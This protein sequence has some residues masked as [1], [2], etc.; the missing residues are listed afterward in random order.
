MQ[1]DL[2]GGPFKT[3]PFQNFVVSPLGVVPK[4]SPGSYRM[5]HH[6]SYPRNSGCSVNEHIPKELTSVA[7]AGI[8]DAIANIKMLGKGCF[9]SKTDVQSAFRI[10]PIHP[11]DYHTLGFSWEG[12]FYYDKA[13]PFGASSSCRLFEATSKALEW[14]AINILGCMAVVHILDDVLFLNSTEQGCIRDLNAFLYAFI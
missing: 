6:L 1:V 12:N 2:G 8:Q 10:I 11:S 3:K 7:Y 14:I 5:I 9:M 13:L 4:K